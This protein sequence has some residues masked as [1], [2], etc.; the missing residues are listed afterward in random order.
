[1]TS[2]RSTRT[3]RRHR[4][5]A[6]LAAALSLAAACSTQEIES[7]P[8]LK[9]ADSASENGN[10]PL[11]LAV[12]RDY[13]TIA[14]LDGTNASGPEYALHIDGRPVARPDGSTWIP[15]DHIRAQTGPGGFVPAGAHVVQL[16]DQN[17]NTALETPPL[18]LQPNRANILVVFGRRTALEHRFLPTDLAVPP[19]IDRLVVLSLI[20]RDYAPQIVRCDGGDPST[21]TAILAGPLAYGEAAQV[22]FPAPAVPCNEPLGPGNTCTG[23]RA[24]VLAVPSRG[25]GEA[26]FL[27][28]SGA[29]FQLQGLLAHPGAAQVRFG[30]LVVL[31][32][33]G[34]LSAGL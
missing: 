31:D 24:S 16:V 12:A 19:G 14:E 18:D 22:D 13:D 23:P 29:D 7:P 21:C 33:P 6:L 15:L 17:G 28:S 4:H 11:I 30:A 20:R 34:I 9:M 3:S 10:A 5:P 1:M 8:F 26:L 25:E 27:P 2:T 32:P